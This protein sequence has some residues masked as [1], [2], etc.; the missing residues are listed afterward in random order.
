MAASSAL[1][2]F[3]AGTTRHMMDYAQIMTH[4]VSGGGSN[5]ENWNNSIATLIG[6]R[7]GKAVE[8]VLTLMAAVTYMDAKTALENGFCDVVEN[9]GVNVEVSSTTNAVKMFEQFKPAFEAVMNKANQSNLPNMKSVTNKL[10]LIEGASEAIILDAVN[11]LEQR[12]VSAESELATNK[13]TLKT[14]Q[15]K[16]NAFESEVTAREKA[17]SQNKAKALIEK[18]QTEG[19]LPV[20]ETDEVKEVLNSWTEMAVTNYASAEKMLAVLPINKQ[21]VKIDQPNGEE[22]GISM[23]AELAKIKN[24]TT[25][26]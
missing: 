13:D 2:I 15:D 12:A 17:E 3:L 4:E 7:T 26:P 14:V 6:S 23:A 1:N 25:K 18:H 22:S 16:L 21:G 24:Q 8:D 10:G 19:R 20:G 9:S 5:S 11:K